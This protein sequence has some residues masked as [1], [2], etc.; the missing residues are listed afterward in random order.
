MLQTQQQQCKELLYAA[1]F[2]E[3]DEVVRCGRPE[4]VAGLLHSLAH[5]PNAVPQTQCHLVPIMHRILGTVVGPLRLLLT[6]Y[7]LDQDSIAVLRIVPATLLKLRHQV[8]QAL[9]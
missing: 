9:R 5:G 7:A 3:K 1:I 8:D 2:L 6:L 4:D